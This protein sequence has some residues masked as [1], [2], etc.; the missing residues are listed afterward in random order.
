MTIFDFDPSNLPDEYLKAIGL[1]VVSATETEAVMRDFIGALLGIDNI[2]SLAI[3]TPMPFRLKDD[4]IRTLNELKAPSDSELD[5]LDDILDRIA[6]A[7]QSRNAIAHSSFPIHP[8]TRQVHRFKEKARGRLSADWV[9]VS[10]EELHSIAKEIHE[11]GLALQ[12]FMAERELGPHHREEPLRKPISR[13]KK[14]R[15]TRRAK[16][17]ERY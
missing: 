9:E 10:P 4:I 16:F 6:E 7:I 12:S 8:E 3:C 17:G 15:E 14:A 11:A 1:I 13:K 2:A 5:K